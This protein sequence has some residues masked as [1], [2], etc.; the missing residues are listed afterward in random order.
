[1][2]LEMWQKLAPIPGGKKVFSKLVG[3][4]APYSGSVGANVIELRPGFAKVELKE[5]RKVR[6]HLNSIHAVALMNLTELATGLAMFV[7]LPKN[8]RLIVKKF[9]I[10]Y[11]KKARGRIT[12][13]A[14]CSVPESDV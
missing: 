14:E 1:M 5:R 13:V 4:Y 9:E 6:N 11:L 12:A 10:E 8:G 2:M 7:A 3:W